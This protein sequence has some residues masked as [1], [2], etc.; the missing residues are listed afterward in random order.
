LRPDSPT[1]V[2]ILADGDNLY[3]GMRAWD[4]DPLG[5]VSYSKARDSQLRGED[6]VKI[7]LDPFLDGQSGWTAELRIPIRSLTGRLESY[8]IFTAP[9]NVRLESVDRIEFDVQ[10]QGARLP[11]PS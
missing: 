4:S 7:I 6:H 8:R 5:P 10:S 2:R 1:E 3:V 11:A 9:V